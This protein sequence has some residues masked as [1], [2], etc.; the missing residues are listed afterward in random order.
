MRLSYRPVHLAAAA[1]FI[2]ALLAA[3]TLAALSPPAAAGATVTNAAGRFDGLV[4][5]DLGGKTGALVQLVAEDGAFSPVELWRSKKGAF[6][7]ARATFVAGDVNGD[8]IG[9]GV[10]LYDLGGGRSRLLVFRSDGSRARQ[11]TAWTSRAGAFARSRARLAVGDVNADGRD[12]VLALYDRGRG[13]AAVYRFTST[14]VKFRQAL[15]WSARRGYS[16]V[17]AQLAAGDATGDGRA[18]AVVLYRSTSTASRLDVF[19]SGTSRSVKKTFWRGKYSAGR[20]RLAAGDVDSDGACD[21]VCLYRASDGDGRL[22]VFAS[23]KRAFQA[24]AVWYEH[25]A[26]SLPFASARL[27]AGDITGDGRADVVVARPSG[28]PASSL[29]VFAASAA[30]FRPSAWW[31]GS[32][33]VARLRLAVGPSAGLVVADRAE[34]LGESSLRCLRRV[35]SDGT[36]HVLRRDRAA[37][38]AGDRRRR[39]LGRHLRAARGHLPQGHVGAGCGRAGGR[40]DRARGTDRRDRPG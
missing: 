19:A 34:V 35:E 23:T 6:D 18:D 5:R 8:G 22:D 4:L 14:G 28:S 15:V 17:G 26:V 36:P 30:G 9:D 21:V 10:V 37:E 20:A 1:V 40:R 31:A 32:W 39:P 29:F 27:A 13:S 3:L 12:D 7:V 25:G 2:L 33:P 16:V 24:P 38:P 11:A